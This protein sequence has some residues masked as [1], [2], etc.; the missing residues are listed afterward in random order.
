[1]LVAVLICMLWSYI[2]WVI[3]LSVDKNK[4]DNWL[5]HVTTGIMFIIVGFLFGITGILINVK[6]YSNFNQFYN[7]NKFI[8]VLSSFGLSIPIIIRGSLVYA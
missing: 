6:L 5:I 1:M 2:A 7:K 8:L 4:Y 3:Y